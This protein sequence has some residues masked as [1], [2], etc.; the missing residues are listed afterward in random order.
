MSTDQSLEAG[1]IAAADVLLAARRTGEA[2][3]PLRE[4]LA[5]GAL[6][7]AYAVQRLNHL[8][9]VGAGAR[10]IG[11]KIGLTS[12]AVQQQLGVDQPDFGVLFDTM[13][14]TGPQAV[15]SA[16]AFIQPRIEGE[17]AFVLAHDITEPG[18]PRD[19]LA[20][21]AGDAVAAFEIVDSA[22]AGW[23]ITLADTVADNAS[24][25]ALVVGTQR[26]PV[27]GAELRLAGMVL[28]EDGR[29][30]STGCGAAS[31]GDPLV[32]FA[33]LADKAVLLGDPLR[34]GEVVLTG[35]LGPMVPFIQ[36]RRY[37]LEI[38]GFDALEVFAE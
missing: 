26:R 5:P 16:A 13:L 15:Q 35:A 11:R 18:L 12:R 17:I 1:V 28:S 6:E 29:Q 30:V 38:A 36:G 7:R 34:A 4:W 8:R 31:L 23:Q 3:A 20:R 32:A 19:E 10:R 24:C 9:A 22:I 14:R 2:V 21:K 37:R 27:A 25:G 33:W